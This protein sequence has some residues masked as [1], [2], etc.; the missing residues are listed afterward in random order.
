MLLSPPPSPLPLFL[1][2]PCLLSVSP[3]FSFVDRSR[4]SPH[5]HNCHSPH[6]WSPLISMFVCRSRRRSL[7]YKGHMAWRSSIGIVYYCKSRYKLGFRRRSR[8]IGV[9]ANDRQ[10]GSRRLFADLIT[11]DPR[12]HQ[13]LKFLLLL[14]LIILLLLLNLLLILLLILLYI[15]LLMLLLLFEI[16]TGVIWHKTNNWNCSTSNPVWLLKKAK[17]DWAVWFRIWAKN[18]KTQES[19]IV[20]SPCKNYS[21]KL[22]IVNPA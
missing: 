8:S 19:Q 12:Y 15:F 1:V 11:I 22:N 10:L 9:S 13:T 5:R 18:H 17:T 3:S 21:F 6:R 2:S 4:R 16:K 7:L 20:L 14:L